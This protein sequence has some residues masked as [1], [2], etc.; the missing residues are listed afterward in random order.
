M[1][2]EQSGKH[3]TKYAPPRSWSVKYEN[4]ARDSPEAHWKYPE[5]RNQSLSADK[6]SRSPTADPV[7]SYYSS[8]N[9]YKQHRH[10]SSPNQTHLKRVSTQDNEALHR[11]AQIT[12]TERDK[13]YPGNFGVIRGNNRRRTELELDDNTKYIDEELE[14][15]TEDNLEDDVGDE[16]EDD[17]EETGESLDKDYEEHE[18]DDEIDEESDAPLQLHRTQ[19]R[20]KKEAPSQS[21]QRIREQQRPN[22]RGFR[23]Q[24]CM[25]NEYD[26]HPAMRRYHTTTNDVSEVLSE[27]EF[28]PHSALPRSVLRSSIDNRHHW[29]QPIESIERYKAA[30]THGQSSRR[31][32]TKPEMES[33]IDPE[34][35]TAKKCS[36]CGSFSSRKSSSNA[37]NNC[38]FEDR[39][40]DS[41]RGPIGDEPII[42]EQPLYAHSNLRHNLEGVG[43]Y[44]IP[45]SAS[46]FPKSRRSRD[47]K[48]PIYEAPEDGQTANDISK[49]SGRNQPKNSRDSPNVFRE[50]TRHSM[51]TAR[52]PTRISSRYAE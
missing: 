2:M 37:R 18:A 45:T 39:L 51:H 30:L 3:K 5:K 21:R 35:N 43:S 36:R 20:V 14:N 29:T 28:L 49:A 34:R 46:Y 8:T 27:E 12:R 6:S 9:S 50:R 26:K 47:V 4:N 24:Q 19:Q 10:Q 31:A 7:A 16:V 48:S 41:T 15:V 33:A 1:A 40:F 25:L 17:Q 52:E 22:A 13:R 38:R 44:D 32:R 23:Y 11:C 42:R